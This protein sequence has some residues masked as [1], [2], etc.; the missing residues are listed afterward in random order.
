[1][2]A[3]IV[4]PINGDFLWYLIPNGVMIAVFYYAFTQKI[5][6][7]VDEKIKEYS[8]EQRKQTL[9]TIDK[10][11]I[12]HDTRITMLD[13]KLHTTDQSLAT[14]REI[15]KALETHNEHILKTIDGVAE[16]MVRLH[17]RLDKQFGK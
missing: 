8:T 1:M 2:T 3:Q 11:E 7:T 14:T 10:I 5:K 12:R 6:Q 4:I 15:V 9:D 16:S 13:A 17:E